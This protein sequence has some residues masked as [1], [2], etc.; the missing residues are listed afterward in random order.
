MRRG[1]VGSRREETWLDI[2]GGN[3]GRRLGRFKSLLAL[4]ERVSTARVAWQ[5]ELHRLGE[6]SIEGD[7]KDR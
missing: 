1:D 6:K 4:R 7:K 5:I 3:D 2:D